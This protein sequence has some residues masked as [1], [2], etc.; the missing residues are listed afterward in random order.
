MRRYRCTHAV[1]TFPIATLLRLIVLGLNRNALP[2]TRRT[3]RTRRRV[4]YPTAE[5]LRGIFGNAPQL[6]DLIVLGLYWKSSSKNTRLHRA[7]GVL[8][9]RTLL[10]S[11]SGRWDCIA[12]RGGL[13][14]WLAS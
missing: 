12:E 2:G 5:I 13:W 1:S 6:M 10:P 8:R 11:T 14:T 7:F 4:S 3:R 9:L